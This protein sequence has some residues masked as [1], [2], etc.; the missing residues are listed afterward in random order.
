MSTRTRKFWGWGY[1]GEGPTAEEQQRLAETLAARFGIEVP[2][3]QPPP[4]IAELNL[5]APRVAPP[6][7]LAGLCT[8]DPLERA[9]HTYGKSFGDVVRAFA[10]H[11]GNPPDVVAFPRSEA[12]V[13]AL[14]DW[15]TDAR[16]AA[17][18]YGGG[19]SVVG[20]VEGPRRG[21]YRGWVSI[22][23]GR[24]DRVLEI[25]RE[26]RAAR[27]QAGV[28][29][30]AL[31]D[32]L[33]PHGLTLRHYPQSFELSTLGGWIAT[34][35]GGHFATLYT[36]IDDFVESLR[37]VTPHGAVESRRLPGSGAGPSPDRLFIGSEG[38]LGVITEAWMRLQD[39]PTFRA[40]TSVTYAD[41]FAAARAVRAIVQAGLYPANCRL[42]DAGEALLSGAGTGADSVLL[43]AFESADHELDAWMHRA[44]ELA[45]AHGGRLADGGGATR[46]Q[47]TGAREGSAGA[48]R[49][50]FLGAPYVRDAIAGLGL[51]SETFETA[52]T[53]D[54]F[55]GFHDAVLRATQDAVRRVC[56]GGTVTCR[57][58]HAYPDGPAPYYSIV[59]PSR[60]GDQL[61][62]WA[63]I[64]A[65]ASEAIIAGGGTITHHHA[66]GR[67]HRPWYDRQRPDGFAA[68]LRAAKR[69][70]DPAGILN[71]GVLIDP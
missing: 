24:L 56:G 8:S 49:A 35:S 2:T 44:E 3:A 36:H 38:I 46:G 32:Q 37:V 20:G 43:I 4:R 60:P 42:L 30:P 59:A 21:D 55:E 14:L 9:G 61:A 33:R 65:A 34:R 23:L 58:T 40:A 45:R 41:F 16:V 67:D 39:R 1:E 28:L 31:E 48:W 6:A 52:I 47:E 17:V 11:F 19:S 53:W 54:R 70:L 50:S 69:A 66:V 51:I 10:R 12:D 26:S 22:D 13:I 63:E 15:C 29:G 18:P 25:D 64:K 62:Q 57:F 27:I 5:R 7:A 71:P 68:A